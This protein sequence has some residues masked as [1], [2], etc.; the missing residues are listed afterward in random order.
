MHSIPHDGQPPQEPSPFASL[1]EAIRKD[2]W[3]RFLAA[4]A[5]PRATPEEVR[6]AVIG[7]LR[8]G[9]SRTHPDLAK[10]RVLLVLLSHPNETLA[11]A[12]TAI[13]KLRKGAPQ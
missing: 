1:P 2:L 7:G 13:G 4:A 5:K 11:L 3:R 12:S 6:N 8:S 10:Y 9:L